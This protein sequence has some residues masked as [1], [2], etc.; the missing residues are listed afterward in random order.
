MPDIPPQPS[1]PSAV[2]PRLRVLRGEEIALG[3]GKAALLEAI[4]AA[5]T[6]TAAAESMG[7]SYMRAWRLVQTM[8]RCFRLPLVATARGGRAKGSASLTREGEAVVGLYR[9]METESLRAT[10][11]TWRQ[12]AA[13]LAPPI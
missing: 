3:P 4:A 7:M 2:Q 5:G 11:S 12:L 6:L 13:R 1:A 8:N 10:R 9:Q